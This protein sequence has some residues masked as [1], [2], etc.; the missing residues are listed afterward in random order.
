MGGATGQTN[1][2]V[3]LLTAFSIGTTDTANIPGLA[4]GLTSTTRGWTPFDSTAALSQHR[5]KIWK[6]TKYFLSPQQTATYQFRDPKRHI[7]SKDSIP[8]STSAN[9][10]G[11]T[12]WLLIVYKPTPGYN[13]VDSPNNDI[14]ELDIG[15]TRKYM[16]KINEDSTDYDA[17]V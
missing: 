12:K 16:Y 11:V 2:A 8:S 9:W 7:F 3:D 13:Y 10:P 17:S 14:S 15:V 5:I 4:T 1:E 6:K